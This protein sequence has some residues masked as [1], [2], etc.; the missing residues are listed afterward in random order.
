MHVSVTYKKINESKTWE[1]I[2]HETK[3]AR[4]EVLGRKQLKRRGKKNT[5]THT[6]TRK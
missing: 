4:R 6:H 1:T 5:H 2:K 3:R